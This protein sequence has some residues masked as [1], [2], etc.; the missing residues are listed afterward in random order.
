MD[1]KYEWLISLSRMINFDFTVKFTFY[2]QLKYIH[3]NVFGC[4][5]VLVEHLI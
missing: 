2:I 5:Y 4:F 3:K 1:D